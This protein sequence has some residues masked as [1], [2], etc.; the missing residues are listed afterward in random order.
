MIFR[1]AFKMSLQAQC[2]AW[3][4]HFTSTRDSLQQ[5]QVFERPQDADRTTLHKHTATFADKP[6]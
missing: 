5:M 1:T 6:L 4:T 3:V 2:E